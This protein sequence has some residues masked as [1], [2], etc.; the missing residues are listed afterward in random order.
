MRTTTSSSPPAA[1]LGQPRVHPVRGARARVPDGR[2]DAGP[3]R[4]LVRADGGVRRCSGRRSLA[5]LRQAP[6]GCERRL[7]RR[8]RSSSTTRTT[9]ARSSSAG[10]DVIG[11]ALIAPSSWCSSSG[12]GARATPAPPAVLLPV[13]LAGGAALLVL[14]LRNLL[15]ADL[16]RAP[17]TP[18]ARSS[19]SLFAAVPFAF[20][21]GI[22]R[23]RLARGSVARPRAS[24]S[25]RACRCATRSP[26][27]SATRRSSSPTGSR[28]GTRYV[29]RDGPHVRAARGRLRP[30]GDDRRA[31]RP[32]AS[33]RSSTTSR[34]RRARA[35]R[36]RRG[37]GR[38]RA[39]QRAA[40]GRAARAVRAA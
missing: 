38:A 10:H 18:S 14:L 27:R 2:L 3:D 40:R 9:L 34:S 8:A 22:L 12:A 1:W 17:P 21:L 11:L 7:P 5:A 31:R 24:R 39:R 16:D 19:S 15:A 25:G 4:L 26:R 36:E 6:A 29:D 20:L 32:S 37:G 28:S 33:A 30:V 23:S 13:Y 35:R